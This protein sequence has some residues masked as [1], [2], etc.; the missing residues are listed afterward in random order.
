[1]YRKSLMVIGVCLIFVAFAGAKLVSPDKSLY[2]AKLDLAKNAPVPGTTQNP[3]G[4]FTAVIPID[5]GGTDVQVQCNPNLAAYNTGSTNASVFL[6]TDTIYACGANVSRGWARFNTTAIPDGSTIDSVKLSFYCYQS[7]GG[8]Y[9]YFMQMSYDPL[10]RTAPQVF[11][12]AGDGSNY[13][14]VYG[15]PTGWITYKLGSTAT[16]D[17]AALLPS[18]WFAVGFYEWESSS[19]YYYRCYGWNSPTLYPYITVWYTAGAATDAGVTNVWFD[20]FTSAVGDVQTIWCTLRNYGTSNLLSIPVQYQ[21]G[22]QPPVTQTWSGTLLPGAST[23]FSFTTTWTPAT[24][25]AVTLACSTKVVGDANA[26]ND[27]N[28]QSIPVFIAGTRVGQLFDLATWLPRGWSQDFVVGASP[29]QRV[30][31]TLYPSGY[32]PLGGT[33][34]C[35]EVNNYFLPIGDLTRLSTHRFNVGTSAQDVRVD[36]WMLNTSQYVS[37]YDSLYIQYSLDSI[38]WTTVGG[39]RCADPANPGWNKKSVLVG[40]F[41]P[42]TSM[43]VGFLN[44][45]RNWHGDIIDSVRTFILPCT[46]PLNDLGV[47]RLNGINT[48]PFETGDPDTIRLT[49]RNFGLAPQTAPVRLLADGVVQPDQPVVTIAAGAT[50]DT[51]I[52]WTPSATGLK[53]LKLTTALVPDAN[54]ANDTLLIGSRYVNPPFYTTGYF[55]NFNEAWT[56]SDNPPWYGWRIKDGGTE[57]PNTLNTNDWYRYD[58]GGGQGLPAITYYPYETTNDSM[59]SPR[60]NLA[61]VLGSL[62]LT[63]YNEYNAWP[64]ASPDTGYISYSTNGGTSWTVL[65]KYYA[66]MAGVLDYDITTWA[67]GQSDVRFVYTYY[68]YD[69]DIW[70]I[71]DFEVYAVPDIPTLTYPG[72]G[73]IIGNASPSFA[74]SGAAGATRFWIQVSDDPGFATL[75]I[76]DSLVTA[77]GYVP[78]APLT[79]GTWYWRVA[80]S[81]DVK[82]WSRWQTPAFSFELDLTPPAAPVLIN[83]ASEAILG[84]ATP[85]FDWGLVTFRNP[86]KTNGS[87][88]D[89]AAVTYRIEVATDSTFPG[90]SIVFTTT[91]TDT[92]VTATTLPETR[93]FWHVR[94]EDA[95]GNIGAY[96]AYWA[97]EIDLTPPAVPVLFTPEDDAYLKVSAPLFQ[98]G[99][100]VFDGLRSGDE[101]GLDA[102]PVTYRIEVATDSTFPAPSIRYTT[103]TTDTFKT[104]SALPQGRLFWHVRGED[105][106]G[107][108]GAYSDYFVFT[109]DIVPP[110]AP[111]LRLPANHASL[112]VATPQFVWSKVSFGSDALIS[113][114]LQVSTESLFAT[115]LINT[116]LAETT[117]TPTTPLGFVK[118][119]WRV[120]AKDTAGNLGPYSARW[121]F[122]VISPT[123][124]WSAMTSLPPGAKSKNVKD[125]GALAYGK[126][127]TD[128]NDTGYVYAFKGNGRYEFYRFNTLSNAW[129]SRESIPAIGSTSKKKP[130]K[131]GATLVMAGDGMV[132]G[133]KGNGTLEW[134]QFD[135]VAN[136]WTEKASVLSGAKALKEGVGSAAV[137]IGSDD[138]VYLLRGSATWDFMRYKVGTDAWETRAPA[139]GGVSTKAY[140]NGSSICY[141]GS[142]TI[143]CLKGSTNEFAAYSIT[144]DNWVTK[145]PLPFIAPPGTKKKKVKDGSGMAFAGGTVYALKG[146][147]TNEFWTYKTGEHKWYTGTEVPAGAKRVKG[148]GA[149]TAARDISRLF[150]FR[151]NNTL[152]FWSYGPVAADGLRLTANSRPKNI[153][154][155]SSFVTRHPSL[156]VTPNPFTS[157][158]NPSISYSLPKAG[159]VSL[160]LYDVAGKIVSVLAGG[161]QAAGSHSCPLPVAHYPLARGVYLLRFESAGGCETRKLVIE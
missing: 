142:D 13:Y 71:D 114:R 131:K 143:Y 152:E 14:S 115:P 128:A 30:T 39:Y 91:T 158:L 65:D 147:G 145:D 124:V 48:Y 21:I 78:A 2:Q 27:K 28:A 113:Y 117:Y 154:G 9:S 15:V 80:S 127:G 44:K 67:A 26:L 24:D 109:I 45:C 92:F 121:D 150:G 6:K 43:L 64:G 81:Q 88:T 82:H 40:S 50:K 130:V 105:G 68:T 11:A 23:N 134:W 3:D 51:F 161:Y 108:I 101:T 103:T 8:P 38:S 46:A 57:T 16:A 22:V 62:H 74:W 149:L 133:A 116:T 141:D 135:P 19:S 125:G 42:G 35:A 98:W 144:G 153:Q 120:M 18:N 96:G 99:T 129:I 140:K 148:G 138:Y 56:N 146:G 7:V 75:L 86:G 69:G 41:L 107:N 132:Y 87:E 136:T 106:A 97:F 104:S 95:A 25:G 59:F 110:A 83:P 157:S 61:G 123:A 84:T 63:F 151:G 89:A 47:V 34:G 5:K 93:L 118:H 70:G 49:V 111:A 58:L 32:L 122:T 112:L 66:D 94:G 156:S 155:N 79:E 10:L 126:E 159:N 37:Y 29:W 139:P 73:D 100:V 36:F 72:D 137:T 17:L 119:Y 4:S 160:K 33:G 31:S 76:N 53:V 102:A 77:S 85:Q 1:M 20:K 60:F 12:D 52:V 90:P 54:N 55:A